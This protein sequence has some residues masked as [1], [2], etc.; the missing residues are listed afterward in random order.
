MLIVTATAANA[1][2]SDATAI[3]AVSQSFCVGHVFPLIAAPI[4]T[5]YLSRHICSFL[6]S[7]CHQRG[8]CCVSPG[9]TK[10]ACKVLAPWS[11]PHLCTR[12][13]STETA[14]PFGLET[15]L[16]LR[17][18]GCHLKQVTGKPSL[19]V[20][21]SA[22]SIEF[23]HCMVYALARFVLVTYLSQIINYPPPLVV[24]PFPSFFIPCIT[25][26][27]NLLS[28]SFAVYQGPPVWTVWHWSPVHSV[29]QHNLGEQCGSLLCSLGC[30]CW[31]HQSHLYWDCWLSGE[32]NS[33][34]PVDCLISANFAF[35]FK[36]YCTQCTLIMI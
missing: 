2:L 16:F 7:N 35:G 22:W 8:R 13:H 5:V 32:W 10:Q 21:V 28:F 3:E 25:V 34:V 18:L 19:S 14:G 33:I 12:G 1:S 26:L 23:R 17:K 27:L 20:D 9:Q 24:P 36:W 29:P 6:P 30:C 31:H 11:M 15:L 4:H